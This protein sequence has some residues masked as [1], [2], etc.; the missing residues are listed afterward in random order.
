MTTA[1]APDILEQAIALID[2]AASHPDPEKAM[3]RL[4]RKASPEERPMFA[5]LWEALVLK[6]NE[7]PLDDHNPG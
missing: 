7:A 3:L 6:L 5:G 2:N 1:P 4:E